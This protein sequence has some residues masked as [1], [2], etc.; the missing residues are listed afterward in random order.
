M[1]RESSGALNKVP[2]DVLVSSEVC[3]ARGAAGHRR[4]KEAGVSGC[5]ALN[6]QISTGNTGVVWE[7]CFPVSRRFHSLV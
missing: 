5:S 3:W 1:G 4:N 7:A 6:P 2:E